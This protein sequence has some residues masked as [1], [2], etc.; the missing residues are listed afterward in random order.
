MNRIDRLTAILIQLQT[1]RIVKAQ[2]I[3]ER[4]DISLRTVYRDIRALEEA[5]VPIGSEAGVGY[6]L[7]RGYFLPPVMFTDEE[8]NSMLLGAKLIEQ[9]S[10]ESVTKEFS[11]ALDK[12]KSVLRTSGKDNLE[13]LNSSIMVSQQFR[14]KNAGTYLA[15]I[16]KAITNSNII[17][18]NYYSHYSE[19]S[20]QRYV[21]PIGLYFY[22][23]AW[24]LIAYCRLR[25]DYRDFRVERIKKLTEFDERFE[26]I[27]HTSLE[28]Y[29]QGITQQ[30]SMQLVKVNFTNEAAKYIHEQK[31]SY[32]FVDEE[33][34][35]SI[36]T[37]S[38]M[39]SSL[40]YFARWI[41]MFGDSVEIVSPEELLTTCQ[42]FV[43]ELNKHYLK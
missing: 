34:G 28:E 21:E 29:I 14:R 31:Y 20:N 36:T 7:P 15:R 26:I 40:D 41:L 9:M 25:E 2:E 16:Q 39:T 43:S 11:S 8:A 1:K 22:S 13:I 24:H 30:F 42:N 17:R 38:F 10:D 3:A 35:E 6:Y 37:M 5:G 12:I 23:N 33:A 4:Y 27:D 18:I 32:G 19:E